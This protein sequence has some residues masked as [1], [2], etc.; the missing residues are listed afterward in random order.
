MPHARPLTRAV[1]IA[2]LALPAVAADAPAGG[3]SQAELKQMFDAKQYKELLPKLSK[4]LA[5]RG[6]AAEGYDRYAL[7]MM[8]GE[9]SLQAHAKLA[10]VD[11]FKQAAKATDDHNLAMTATADAVL[12]RD[13]NGAGAYVPK[14][15]TPKGDKP[16]PIDILAPDSRKTAFTALEQ[17]LLAKAK[18][19][20]EAAKHGRSL[21]QIMDAARGLGD[22]VPVEYAAD[23]TAND[24][25]AYLGDLGTRVCQLL[26]GDMDHT[27]DSLQTDL[28]SFTQQAKA[29]ASE[30]QIRP[31]MM[32]LARD[33]DSGDAEVAQVDGVAKQMPTVFGTVTD[34]KPIEAKAAHLHQEIDQLR[35][36]IDAS[37]FPGLPR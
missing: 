24:V 31:Y 8:K 27:V 28:K 7:F 10:A 35:R 2:L 3:D 19:R 22:A 11:A 16:E 4:V 17:D 30:T 29:N 14:T 6:P 26:D 32:N 37:G 36:K 34:F 18:P 5:L 23:G 25:N 13:A 15:G 9:S 21:S 1:L 20:V 33:T 12:A